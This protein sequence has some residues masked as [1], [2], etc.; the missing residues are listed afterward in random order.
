MTSMCKISYRYNQC[1]KIYTN[2]STSLIIKMEKEHVILIPESGSLYYVSTVVH[3]HYSLDTELLEIDASLCFCL[4]LKETS[5]L[6][7]FDRSK[8]STTRY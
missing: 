3:Q 7:Y 8:G 5:Y 1:T 6:L 2:G 4:E